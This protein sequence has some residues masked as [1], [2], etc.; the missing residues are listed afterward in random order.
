MDV[1]D[2]WADNEEVKREYGFELKENPNLSEYDGIV[3]A[4]AHNE[5][6]DIENELKNKKTN[7]VIYDI[8]GFF[9]KNSVDGRL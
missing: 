9:D 2:P 8:K 4:V 1:Y 3:L 6:K 5:F 7:Q